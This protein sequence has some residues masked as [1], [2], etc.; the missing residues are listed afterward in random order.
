[1]LPAIT[2][3]LP[4]YLNPATRK[5]AGQTTTADTEA[6]P[7]TRVEL[8][9]EQTLQANS[10]QPGTGIYGPDGRFVETASRRDQ[11]E[12]SPRENDKAAPSSLK[13]AENSSNRRK[14]KLSEFAAVVPPAAREEL[15]AL[16]DRVGRQS[17]GPTLTAR[18][19]KLVAD[20][21]D[22]VGRYDEAKV[23]LDKARELEEGEPE[24]ED[25]NDDRSSSE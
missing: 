13:T 18:D 25:S 3:D 14:L 22:R 17:T 4:A 15:K 8:S 2:A 1:M 19:Y 9:T 16:A 11:S 21:M 24:P 6:N 7:A 20:L 10:N 23:A 12:Q 5:A